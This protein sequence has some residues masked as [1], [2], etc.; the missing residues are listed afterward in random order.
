M[1]GLKAGAAKD[2]VKEKGMNAGKLVQVIGPVVDV[3]F[4]EGQLP[5][6]MNAIAIS[7]PTISDVEDNLIVEVAQHL[8]DNV[9]RCIAMDITDG[10]VRGMKAKDLGGPISVPVGPECLGRILNVVGRPVDGLGPVEA[11]HTMPIHREAPTFLEQDTSVH[12][13]ETGVKVIDL[14]VPFPRGGKMGMFGGAGVGKTVVMMEMIH[15][16]AMHHGGISVFAGVGERT[17]EGNDLYLEMK[18]S[19]VIKQA[20]LIYGQMTEPPG[21]RARVALTALAAA[22]YFRDVEGQDVLLFIDNIFRFTQAG[23]EVSALLGRMPSAVGYQPTLAT[24]LGELQER[25][26]STNK[27]SIT[28]VQCVYVPADDLTDPAPATT[29]AHLDGTVVLSR[30]IAEL[31]I[32]PA[33]DPLDSTSRILDPN[34]LGAEHYQVARQVQVTLQKYKD[35]QDIIAILGMDELSEGDKVTVSRARKIQRFLSQPFFV[36][37][38]FT[39]TEGKFVTVADTVRG[40]KEILEG[41]H[42]D[43]PEQAFY[44]VG[45]IEEVVEKA[46]KLAE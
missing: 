38:Q 8:G 2:H 42:D 13:L 15:N 32:H 26:T 30:P 18:A 43:L 46:K 6:I 19:G 17:R 36:A 25:I 24:D 22:E 14:L 45:G 10:L 41:K 31:G 44:M 7:N 39:G 4:D 34:V 37:A 21:A 40:F 3:A 35:L 20:A 28:A 23:S 11:K 29:F 5:N 16:I 12:V 1:G 27:G 9:V 33:V